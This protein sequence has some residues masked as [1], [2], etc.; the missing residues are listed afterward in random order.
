MKR[1]LFFAALFFVVLSCGNGTEGRKGGSSGPVTPPAPR[2][3]T[4]TLMS[5]NVGAF[6][7]YRDD[8]GHF[9]YPEVA[10]VIK[11]VDAR[12]VGLNETDKGAVRTLGEFQASRLADALGNGWSSS[13]YNAAYT[14]YGNSM[15]WD[16]YMFPRA[17]VLE[18]VVLDKTDGSEVRSMGA[19]EFPDFVFCVT[20]L[21]HVSETDR[22]N[23]IDKITNWATKNHSGKRVF[24]V[25]DMNAEPTSTTIAKLRE[26]WLQL[27]GNEPSFPSNNPQK[28][29]DYIFAFKNGHENELEN[30][31]SVLD[32]GVITPD[33][34]PEVATA[35]DHC[36]VWA[37]LMFYV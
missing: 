13:F 25:G 31:I 14:W 32:T 34:V 4:I 9:S 15:V 6:N 29:I 21:D 33:D 2:E 12:I 30:D 36:P 22:L 28:C 23:A 8:L 35:S 11:S 16:R 5:Y 24:L 19:V 3:V 37:K 27:S 18:R 7:K 17:K 20:H 10:K 26:N 1:I